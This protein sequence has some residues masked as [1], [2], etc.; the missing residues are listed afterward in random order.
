MSSDLPALEEATV[1]SSGG[2]KGLILQGY[3][4][5]PA[6]CP[7]LCPRETELRLFIVS[8]GWASW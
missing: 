3:H 7:C 2:D 8:E 4:A 5:H 6:Q 1:V